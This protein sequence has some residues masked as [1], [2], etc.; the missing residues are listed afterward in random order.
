[1][2]LSVLGAGDFKASER[3]KNAGGHPQPD[4]F[5]PSIRV[6]LRASQPESKRAY[7]KE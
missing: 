7:A 2:W 5:C 3:S 1:M 6:P 4:L